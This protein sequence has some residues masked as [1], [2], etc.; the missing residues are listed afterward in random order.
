MKLTNKF[1]LFL[2]L[3]ISYG[4]SHAD[5]QY[6]TDFIGAV[7]QAIPFWMQVST[8][9]AMKIFTILWCFETFY[10][11]TFKNVL[12]NNLKQLPVYFITRVC[13]GGFFYALL[14]KP[15]FYLGIIQYFGS[16]TTA[17]S[18]HGNLIKGFDAG[19][20][21]DQ[22]RNW[23]TSVYNPVVE[24][25]GLSDMGKIITYGILYD[26]YMVCSCLIAL[27]IIILEIQIYITVFGALVLTG[28]AGSSWTY[29]IWNKYIDTVIGL[30]IRVMV[31]GMLYGIL[32]KLI[33]VNP[34]TVSS[35]SVVDSSISMIIVTACLWIIPSQIS[36]MVSGSSAGHSL[37]E[38]GAAVFA[39]VALGKRMTSKITPSFSGSNSV[40]GSNPQ[41]FRDT[42]V[43]IPS[44]DIMM[45]SPNKAK[46]VKPMPPD[47]NG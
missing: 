35:L 18:I 3:A 9:T 30:G 43:P 24:T 46:A 22:F 29:N 23:T 41:V 45:R 27:M 7:E 15:D 31:F 33:G 4:Y 37:A 12:G 39:S 38:A 34:S 21:F 40:T 10:Q 47:W 14:L 5:T 20:V 42:H 26:I 11:V 44:N 32:S 1:I 8:N 6:H 17:I 2:V 36:S 13:F 16:Q 28:F 19:W 25:L